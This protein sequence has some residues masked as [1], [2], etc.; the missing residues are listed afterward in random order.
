MPDVISLGSLTL[1]L[2][3][4]DES[5]TIKQGRFALALGGKY[6]ASQFQEGVGGGG[7][8][9]AIGIARAGI[10][11]AL[12]SHIGIGGLSLFIRD[13]LTKENV[14]IS[15]LQEEENFSNISAILLSGSGERTIITHRSREV[16]L[17]IKP[18]HE[19]AISTCRLFFIGNMP[20][21]PLE[22]RQRLAA[23]ASSQQHEVALNFGVKDCRK[24]LGALS[25]LLSTASL[26]IVNKHELGDMLGQPYGELLPQEI[27]YHKALYL[28][29]RAL[30]VITDGAFGS[31]AQTHN[32]IFFQQ[33]L[34]VEHIVDT[35]G[36]GDAFTSGFL[37]AHI[38]QRSIPEALLA[39]ARNSQ[40]VIARLTAQEGLLTKTELGL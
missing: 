13:Q 17:A 4:R 6:V 8:N 2:F 10:S 16:A 25:S 36:A 29:K 21:M 35:T 38:Y 32:Q 12:W 31:Y 28:H 19:K 15:L 27:N 20:D 9:V 40:S 1:D 18:Q 33:A 34:P 7:A 3:F 5:L 11:S 39:G 26:L 22:E 14:D 37:A 23:L 24:G 30:L